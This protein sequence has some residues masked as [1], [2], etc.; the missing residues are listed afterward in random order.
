MSRTDE[1]SSGALQ[2]VI[3]RAAAAIE[4]A[5]AIIILAGA[6]MGVDS[7]LPDYRI[8][9]C[10]GNI[11]RHQCIHIALIGN[12]YARHDGERRYWPPGGVSIGWLNV[13]VIELLSAD[14]GFVH[15]T[16]LGHGEYGHSPVILTD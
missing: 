4:Q 15:Q 9:E 16:A 7:G 14:G 6:G 11:H 13:L 10:H 3:E 8:V 2:S 1:T 12:L 5:D